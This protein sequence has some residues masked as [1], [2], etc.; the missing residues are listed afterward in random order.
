MKLLEDVE[1]FLQIILPSRWHRNGFFYPMGYWAAD[2]KG[3]F[4]RLL[5]VTSIHRAGNFH[6]WEQPDAVGPSMTFKLRAARE[7][8]QT[9]VIRHLDARS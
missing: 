7:P 5:S 3:I 2:K 8:R 4:S 6:I 9:L 1:E